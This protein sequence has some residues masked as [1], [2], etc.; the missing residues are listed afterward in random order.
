MKSLF[1]ALSLSP[2]FSG[3][4]LGLSVSISMVGCNSSN[5]PSPLSPVETT[6]EQLQNHSGCLDLGLL[7]KRIQKAK[8]IRTT[9]VD[10]KYAKNP[11]EAMLA[12]SADSSNDPDITTTVITQDGCK[13]LTITNASGEEEVAT[14]IEHKRNRLRFQ[15]DAQPTSGTSETAVSIDMSV[16]LSSE[17]RMRTEQ[18]QPA[19]MSHTCNGK[20]VEENIQRT[21]IDEIDFGNTLPA[22]SKESAELSELRTKTTVAQAA[23][24]KGIAG[25]DPK[26]LETQYCSNGQ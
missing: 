16:E 4:V 15:F 9:A 23:L 10:L 21:E 14:I 1:T 7:N 17:S 12:N 18:I 19:V 25:G 24:A 3:L 13:T 22:A 2:L 8:N 11:S 5:A 6:I 26:V 20:T